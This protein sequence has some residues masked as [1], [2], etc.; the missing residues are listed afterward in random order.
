[1]CAM[2]PRRDQLHECQEMDAQHWLPG[3]VAP[4]RQRWFLKR[5]CHPWLPL[6]APIVSRP[7][8]PWPGLGMAGAP[9]VG[10]GVEPCPPWHMLIACNGE[11]VIGSDP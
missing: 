11:R 6:L 7:Q 4:D 3:L 10:D 5:S 8:T 1:M 9:L 2:G